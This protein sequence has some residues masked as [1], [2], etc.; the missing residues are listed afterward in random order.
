[1]LVTNNI[2]FLNLKNNKHFMRR[3]LEVEDEISL[4]LLATIFILGLILIFGSY[5]IFFDGRDVIVDGGQYIRDRYTQ[6]KYGLSY[7][8]NFDL[9][10]F[11][12]RSCADCTI[13]ATSDKN[14]VLEVSYEIPHNKNK[15]SIFYHKILERIFNVPVNYGWVSI[16]SKPNNSDW[17]DYKSANFFVKNEGK[18][19]RLEFSIEESD[20][21]IW[22]YFNKDAIKTTIGSLVSMPFNDFVHPSWAPL[23]DGKKEFNNI[24]MFQ[25]TITSFDKAVSNTLEFSLKDDNLIYLT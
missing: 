16:N 11:N 6:F 25:M 4:N 13:A 10:N 9:N 5:F 19:S 3:D 15:I 22:Y 20:G 8:N 21:D 7:I 1:M 12:F 14:G 17:S 2:N 18:T 23:G 24:T